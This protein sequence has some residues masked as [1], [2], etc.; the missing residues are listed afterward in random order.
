MHLQWA[1]MCESAEQNEQGQTT[2]VNVGKAIERIPSLGIIALPF[3]VVISVR[4]E[5]EELDKKHE[6]ALQMF[7]PDGKA[8]G[9]RAVQVIPT[10]AAE[11]TDVPAWHQT[12]A[13][14][15][16]DVPLPTYGLYE[17]QVFLDGTLAHTFKI[18]I[19]PM[20]Q[21]LPQEGER[22]IAGG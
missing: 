18:D 19:A 7:S 14:R 13:L 10:P 4:Y 22:V 1:V 16:S 3:L 9:D 2:L 12:L 8:C 17:L 20:P 15:L 21:M 6:A 5:L 11:A